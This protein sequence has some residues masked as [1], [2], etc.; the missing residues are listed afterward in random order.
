[1][2]HRLTQVAHRLPVVL[3]REQQALPVLLI[4]ALPERKLESNLT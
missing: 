4:A 1:M 2:E 3:Q